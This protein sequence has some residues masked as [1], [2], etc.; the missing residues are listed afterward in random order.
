MPLFEYQCDNCGASAEILVTAGS[1]VDPTCR[2]CGSSEM[3]KQ[4]SVPSSFSGVS[5]MSTPG[6]GDTACCGVGPEEAGCAGPGSCC[7]ANVMGK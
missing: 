7:G 4:L 3:K 5:S 1:A 2:S 6:P